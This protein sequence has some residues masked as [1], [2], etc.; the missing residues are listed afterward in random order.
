MS[1]CDKL[2]NQAEQTYAD[3]IDKSIETAAAC[4]RLCAEGLSRF[5][6]DSGGNYPIQDISLLIACSAVSGSWNSVSSADR[7]RF[8]ERLKL[9]VSNINGLCDDLPLTLTVPGYANIGRNLMS[10]PQITAF[11]E[12]LTRLFQTLDENERMAVV[13]MHYLML[14]AVFERWPQVDVLKDAYERASVQSEETYEPPENNT[15][16][17]PFSHTYAAPAQPSASALARYERN[18]KRRWRPL[19]IYLII[20]GL[21]IALVLGL[22]F[23]AAPPFTEGQAIVVKDITGQSVKMLPESEPVE[24]A[25]VGLTDYNGVVRLFYGAIIG[26]V[27]YRIVSIIAVFIINALYRRRNAKKAAALRAGNYIP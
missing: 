5:S 13:T 27:V 26:I 20:T 14:Y 15:A 12:H 2:K 21:F 24:L 10:P 25:L 6:D 4:F 18:A 16:G 9:Y 7:E 3:G 11:T 23:Y 17:V 22:Y 8:S 19:K 1:I